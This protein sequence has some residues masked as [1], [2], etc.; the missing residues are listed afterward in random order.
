MYGYEVVWLPLSDDGEA[1][2]MLMG[3]MGYFDDPRRLE[4]PKLR[5]RALDPAA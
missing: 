2:S 5:Q 4:Q 1:V 3:G